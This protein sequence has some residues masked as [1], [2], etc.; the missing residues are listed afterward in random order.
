MLTEYRNS[1][2][3]YFLL[4]AWMDVGLGLLSDCCLVPLRL[5]CFAI[6]GAPKAPMLTPVL[7]TAKGGPLKEG[8]E[9]AA[10]WMYIQEL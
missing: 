2:V 7:G 10:G 9:M 6:V 3:I 4:V 1:E 5:Q 8:A